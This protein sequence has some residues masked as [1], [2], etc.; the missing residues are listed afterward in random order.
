MHIKEFAAM[1]GLSQSK[2]RFYEKHGLLQTER[3][4]NGYREFVPE[5]AFRS[6]AFLSLKKYG[7]SV[8]DA[9]RMLDERQRTEEFAASLRDKREEMLREI[10]L[11]RYRIQRIDQALDNMENEPDESCEV[12]DV[13]DY[14]YVRAS[15]G[16]DFS[17]ALGV[18]REIRDYYEL[19]SV[20]ACARIIGKEDLESNA[21]VTDPSYIIAVPEPDIEKLPAETRA[22]SERFALG[23]CIRFRRLATRAESAQ[24][25]SYAPLFDFMDQ[26]GYRL[27]G[28]V[29]LVPLFLNL[30][31]KG[32]DIEILFVPI[33]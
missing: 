10:E 13:P 17:A 9:V 29:L 19:L 14:F 32:K 31:G 5:D 18:A 16:R 12:V 33:D 27:H 4:V 1:T 26:H 6:N 25:Q 22:N 30:D 28:D 21:D 3:Q 2:I 24:K 23:R 15:H 8:E 7:F 20:T 11:L